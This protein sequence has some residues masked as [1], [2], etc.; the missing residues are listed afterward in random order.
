MVTVCRGMYMGV[1]GQFFRV[2]SLSTFMWFLGIEFRYQDCSARCLYLMRHLTGLNA[3]KLYLLYLF[4]GLGCMT[5]CAYGGQ[6]LLPC[7]F[8]GL[9]SKSLG[10][11]ARAF[12]L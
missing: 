5:W 4:G 7:G 8:Q 1:R 12:T 2:G 9:N 11:A 6:I 3:L 10:L